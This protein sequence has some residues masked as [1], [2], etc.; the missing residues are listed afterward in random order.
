VEILSETTLKE[1]IGLEMDTSPYSIFIMAI[2]SPITREKYLQRLV[3]FLNFI[4][5]GQK[6]EEVEERCNLLVFKAKKD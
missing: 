3:Y 4:G 2:N 5:I 6:G 1:Q